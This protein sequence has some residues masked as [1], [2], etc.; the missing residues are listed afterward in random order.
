MNVRKSCLFDTYN[1]INKHLQLR[2]MIVRKKSSGREKTKEADESIAK[3][4]VRTIL[5]ATLNYIYPSFL[6]SIAV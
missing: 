1:N 5:Y 6:P 3:K 2:I 4:D